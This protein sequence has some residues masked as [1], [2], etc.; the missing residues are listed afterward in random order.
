[1]SVLFDKSFYFGVICLTSI[2]PIKSTNI[3]FLLLHR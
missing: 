3:N 2:L 1:V